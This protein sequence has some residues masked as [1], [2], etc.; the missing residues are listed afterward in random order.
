VTSLLSPAEV[1]AP[2]VLD[3]AQFGDRAAVHTADGTLTYAELAGRVDAVAAR[4]GDTRRLVLVE[5]A[6]TV[7]SLTA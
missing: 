3:L 7:E 1:H 6:N 4:L 2:R 5:G